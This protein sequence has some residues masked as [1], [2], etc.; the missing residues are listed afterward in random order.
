[1]LNDDV[2]MTPYCNVLPKYPVSSVSD[3]LKCLILTDDL[4]DMVLCIPNLEDLYYIQQK[5]NQNGEFPAFP[6][7]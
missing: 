1:M 7:T 5:R 3:K 2:N 4:Y 6:L